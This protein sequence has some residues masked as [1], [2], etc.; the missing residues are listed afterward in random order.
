[1]ARK[2]APTRGKNLIREDN[3]I[4][5]QYGV[6]LSQDEVTRMRNLVR[7]VN[8]KRN[9]MVKEFAETPLYYGGK[10]LDEDRR[11]LSLM[12]EEM[13]IMIRKRSAAVN[14]FKSKKDFNAY[15]RQLDRVADT[16]YLEYRTKLYKRNLMN[17]IQEKYGQYPDQIKGIIMKIRMM[18]PAEFQKL[19][20]SDRLF[21]I[22]EHY[23]LYGDINRLKNMRERLGLRQLDDYEEYE[24][25]Q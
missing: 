2:K 15:V 23:N 10:K 3:Y 7:R 21:Q 14:Q 13:D 20:A 12:G 5:N 11:Q 4:T 22:K 8:Y 24:D 18:K 25:E 1:M 16:D 9:K 19:I 17:T 6:K